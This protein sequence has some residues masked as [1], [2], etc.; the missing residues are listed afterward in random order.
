M[1]HTIAII[2]GGNL[3]ASLAEGLLNSDFV[4]PINYGLPSE[5]CKPCNLYKI[6]GCM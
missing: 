1:Q 4:P 3:G 5:M 2:G 6:K